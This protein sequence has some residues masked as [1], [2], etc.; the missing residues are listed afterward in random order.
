MPLVSAVLLKHHQK[1]LS[2]S[3]KNFQRLSVLGILEASNAPKF[4]CRANAAS[5]LRVVKRI[6]AGISTSQTSYILS[7]AHLHRAPDGSTY[8]DPQQ[9]IMIDTKEKTAET[10]S[11]SMAD[12]GRC[13]EIY[14]NGKEPRVTTWK[15]NNLFLS[16][17]LS[18]LIMQ[19]FSAQA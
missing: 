18:T 4:E 15:E 12:Q 13:K 16:K 1:N 19:G 6:S 17:W 2:Q 3:E 9:E 11:F 10:I 5:P 14:F 8:S 7:L